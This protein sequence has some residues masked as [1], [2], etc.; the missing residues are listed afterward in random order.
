[1][2][3]VRRACLGLAV[4]ALA[5]EAPPRAAS[6]DEPAA[7]S[8]ADIA[9]AFRAKRYAAAYRASLDARDQIGKL[10]LTEIKSAFPKA[11]QGWT[12]DAPDDSWSQGCDAGWL[13]ERRYRK[14]DATVVVLSI[15]LCANPADK[16][17]EG[18]VVWLTQGLAGTSGAP[19]QSKVAVA[20][21]PALL[22]YDAKRR[23]GT[24]GFFLVPEIPLAIHGEGV[25]RADL[26]ETFGQALD[27]DALTKSIARG[28]PEGDATALVEAL[29]AALAA[30]PPGPAFDACR[31]LGPK[32][33]ALANDALK[34]ILP[35]APAA[36]RAGDEASKGV[37]GPLGVSR[38]YSKGAGDG[39]ASV[40]MTLEWMESPNVNGLL[41]AT[42]EP[43]AGQEIVALGGKRAVLERGR[44]GPDS[45]DSLYFFVSGDAFR[46][47][48]VARGPART[49]W[50]DAFTKAIDV[51]A[52]EK[53]LAP[54]R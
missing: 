29:T 8:P 39:E 51:A 53:A 42:K 25:A 17:S 1:M 18:N 6:A 43:R 33:V 26:E 27:L 40:R 12:A 44:A 9:P 49:G 23:V 46:L 41:D 16:P 2:G 30:P 28:A 45:E 37:Y 24:L 21:R 35:P 22:D 3:L 31:A 15:D 19:T 11:P 34:G 14:G 54:L 4:L 7:A 47:E 48:M 5:G 36:W 52:L 20:G 38:A 10:W 13:V 32:L 50:V